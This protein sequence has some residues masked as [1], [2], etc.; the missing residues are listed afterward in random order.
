MSFSCY[1]KRQRYAYIRRLLRGN[2]RCRQTSGFQSIRKLK[3][4]LIE[5]C[6]IRKQEGAKWFFGACSKDLELVVRQFTFNRYGGNR[7][8]Y[9]LF[10]FL[11]GREPLKMGMP[12]SWRN[13][14][15]SKDWPVNHLLSALNWQALI[16]LRYLRGVIEIV[17]LC[18]IQIVRSTLNS[19]FENYVYMPGLSSANL[20]PLVPSAKCYNV[21]S[22]YAQWSD[23][24]SNITSILHDVKG[25]QSRTI[26]C[27]KVEFAPPPYEFFLGWPG[28]FS[29][30]TWGA[31]ASLWAGLNM[32]VGRW[33]W[34]LM[35]GEA[36]KAKII[37]Q[38]TPCRLASEYL[39]HASLTNYR[40]MWTY[41]V[42]LKGAQVALYFYSTSAQPTPPSGP[43]NQKYLWGPNTWPKFVVWD[44]YQEARVK[45]ALGESLV[46][47]IGGPIFFSDNG[48]P[49]PELP[50]HSIAVFD[51]QPHRLSSHLGFSTLADCQAVY[52][53]FYHHF[54]LDVTEILRECGANI[55]LKT[56]REIGTRG[57]RRYAQILKTLDKQTDIRFINPGISAFRLA[58][59]CDASISAPFTSTAL[60]AKNLG[61]PSIYYDPVGWMQRD[62]EAAHGIPVLCGKD[63]LRV[64]V[65]QILT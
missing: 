19:H 35:L 53:D 55:A 25:E 47:V 17:R 37:Q 54:I 58:K 2:A 16:A 32:L 30:L 10:H 9:A 7:L 36:A 28:F 52:P 29:F 6:V 13:H 20:P 31:L 61:R 48:A 34:A 60:Y 62:D 44:K 33:E 4:E 59:L 39:F 18:S 11:G 22:W 23:K 56:K 64:W 8:T 57:D 14:L 63:E 43:V 21:C 38:L 27:Y 41:E 42:E 46:V 45:L 1:F 49:L 5:I 3:N 50:V 51:I 24:A 40:P 65:N 26:D 12:A 15:A